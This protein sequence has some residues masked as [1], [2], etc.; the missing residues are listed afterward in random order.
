MPSMLVIAITAVPDRLR[1][2]RRR[3][4]TEVVPGVLGRHRLGPRPRPTPGG[5]HPARR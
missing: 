4:T 3:W 1:G 5:R 2:A